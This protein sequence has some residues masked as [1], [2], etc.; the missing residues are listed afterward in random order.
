MTWRVGHRWIRDIEGVRD[1]EDVFQVVGLSVGNE[2]LQRELP[3]VGVGGNV[4]VV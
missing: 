2:R 3:T 1:H 4:I